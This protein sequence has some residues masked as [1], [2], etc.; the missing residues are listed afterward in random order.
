MLLLSLGACMEEQEDLT[1][2]SNLPPQLAQVKQWFEANKGQLRIRDGGASFR[3]ESQELILPFFEKEPDW[4]RV[5]QYSFPDGREV[6]EIS[7]ANAQKYFPAYLRDSLQTQD[8][9]GAVIQNIMF[10]KNPETGRFDP[11][12]ARYYPNSETSIHEFGDIHYNDIPLGW[13]GLV[14][15]WTYDE[16]FFAAFAIEDGEITR[17]FQRVQD[18]METGRKKSPTGQNYDVACQYYQ[19]TYLAY[20]VSAGGVTTEHLEYGLV[21]EC[22]G[23]SLPFEPTPVI[24]TYGPASSPS[25]NYGGVGGSAPIYIPVTYTPPPVP[26]PMVLQIDMRGLQDCHKEILQGLIGGTQHELRRI[27]EKFN[28]NQPVPISYNVKFRY[29]TCSNPLSNACTAPQIS[30]GFAIVTLNKDNLANATDLSI[31]RT[32][33]HEMLHAYLIFEAK[34]PS[35]CDLNNLLNEYMKKNGIQIL[36]QNDHHRLFVETKFLN[37]IEVE[38]K[39]FATSVGYNVETLGN[40]YFKDMAWGGLQFT[41]VY[42]SL[43]PAEKLRISNILNSEAN[44]SPSGNTSP[45]G[46]QACN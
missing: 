20:T 46:I 19:V 44:S 23:G 7:L 27:F 29:G 6:F 45:K 18:E 40:Q 8:P 11:L 2:V 43:S 26:A 22:S 4:E 1:Q 42:N 36:T 31:A 35:N 28:G 25:G 15:I 10:V 21:Y 5:H 41:D 24:Y 32:I 37:D 9:A 38:L 34:Y 12:I 39:K 17:V 13:S 3:T 33:M 30:N 16:R 14:D